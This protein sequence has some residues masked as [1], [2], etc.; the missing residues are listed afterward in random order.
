MSSEVHN[1]WH[2]ISTV[3]FK[4]TPLSNCFVL[5]LESRKYIATILIL[6]KLKFSFIC[7]HFD[8]WFVLVSFLRLQCCINFKEPIFIIKLLCPFNAFF[9]LLCY[10]LFIYSNNR[11]RWQTWLWDLFNECF[12]SGLV[13]FVLLWVTRVLWFVWFRG[14]RAYFSCN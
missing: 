8:G 10:F 2:K 5:F 13:D 9:T 12:A 7:K 3:T 4:R 14:I 6:E 1:K 11:S